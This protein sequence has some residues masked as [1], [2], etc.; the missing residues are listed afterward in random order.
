MLYGIDQAAGAL[1]IEAD[2]AGLQGQPIT[3]AIVM[4]EQGAHHFDEYRDSDGT[5]LLGSQVGCWDGVAAAEATFLASRQRVAFSVN[6]VAG[7]GS[8]R[9]NC[10]IQ[11]CLVGL[12]LHHVPS[13]GAFK[14]TLKIERLL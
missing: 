9:R 6:R 2:F 14:S 8:S 4:H 12:R 3:E 1:S 7:R 10:R 13:I 11:A 5:R